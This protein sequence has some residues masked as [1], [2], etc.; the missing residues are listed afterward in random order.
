MTKDQ[1]QTFTLRV[2]RAN[3]TEMIAILYD[4]GIVYLEDALSALDGQDT[5]TFRLNINRAKDV[6]RELTASVNT[7]NP[8]GKKFLSLYVFYNEQLTKAYMDLDREACGHVLKMFEILSA[9]Y[10]EAAKKDPDGAVMG[11]TENIYTGLTY[12]RYQTANNYSDAGGNR[13]YL[14]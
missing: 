5:K 3:R 12:N 10:K 11:N 4:I 2:S 9:G 6:L 8:L 13:G 7:A 1:I 14:A